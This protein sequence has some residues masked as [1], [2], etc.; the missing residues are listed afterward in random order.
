MY[1]SLNEDFLN[2]TKAKAKEDSVAE[3]GDDGK[4]KLLYADLADKVIDMEITE[5]SINIGFETD[6]G[7]F[8]VDIPLTAENWE[9]LLTLM[10]KRMNKIKT[11]MEALK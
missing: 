7:Y 4:D 3:Y 8:S 5:D 10:I 6:L 1:T 2:K 9:T 11:M